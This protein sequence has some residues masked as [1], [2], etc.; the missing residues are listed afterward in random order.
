M[1]LAADALRG[2]VVAFDL[3][4]T[5][6]DTA[7]DLVGT[8]NILLAEH[9]HPALPM[10]AA[11]PMIGRG[12]MVMIERGFAA[13]GAEIGPEAAPGLYARFIELYRPRIA[14]GSRPFPGLT[15]ALDALAEA[16]A[17]LAVCTNKRTELSTLL[18]EKLGLAGRFAA[19]V[20]PDTAGASKPD[21]RHLI[22]AAEAAGGRI[23]QCLMVGDAAPDV[24][25]AR[26]A[27]APVVA[28]S[29]GYA[30]T[31]VADLGADV[32]IDRFADLADAVGGLL[33]A[34]MAA[35]SR[36]LPTADGRATADA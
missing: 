31:P 16:G 11:K 10:E 25:A 9:G 1:S 8:L 6:I 19:I 5:L 4:G 14:E 23:E 2:W 32:V 35:I 28:V 36:R 24:N 26:A 21:P 3:D 17:A 29:F 7:P 12:A 30:E 34:R 15:E 18:L 13:A 33:A 20:G 27:G 22:A